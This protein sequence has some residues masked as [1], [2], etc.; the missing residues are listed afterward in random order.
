MLSRVGLGHIILSGWQQS[1]LGLK[2]SSSSRERRV[3]LHR[4]KLVLELP[5]SSPQIFLLYPLTS[6]Q[7]L[8]SL[9]DTYTSHSPPSK[10]SHPGGNICDCFTG[11]DG[12]T[13]KEACS[14]VGLLSIK[15]QH[16]ASHAQVHASTP[17][18][19]VVD[20]VDGKIDTVKV[21]VGVVYMPTLV[22]ISTHISRAYFLGRAAKAGD[23]FFGVFSG[24]SLF[25][26]APISEPT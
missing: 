11:C 18:V 14:R 4:G 26:S 6:H 12:L 25:L 8:A 22:L 15:G 16:M 10:V 7:D 20:S 23:C 9:G 17:R 21:F 1:G 13:V 24:H 19:G 3:Q 5:A 2:W